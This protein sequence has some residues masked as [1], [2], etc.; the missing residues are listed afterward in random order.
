MP[1][2]QLGLS[3]SGLLVW[4]IILIGVA[5]SGFKI[6]PAYYEYSVITKNLGAIV[7]ETNIQNAD[8]HQ[9]RASFAKRAQIDNITSIGGN[10]IM[11]HKNQGRIVLGADYTIRIPL[12]ANLSLSI[13]FQAR[14]E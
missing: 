14:S 5:F 1:P 12:I 10:D 4:S 2:K 7:K 13:N 3:L 6:A 8:L 9:I 11:I